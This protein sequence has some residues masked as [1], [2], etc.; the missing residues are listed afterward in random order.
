[1]AA[2]LAGRDPDEHATLKV[3]GVV[4]FDGPLWRYPDFLTRAETAY[5][6]LVATRLVRPENLNGQS[7][8]SFSSAECSSSTGTIDHDSGH[9][10]AKTRS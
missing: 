4:A 6:V 1:M 2:R 9:Y 7:V 8:S 3:G 5:E 10:S